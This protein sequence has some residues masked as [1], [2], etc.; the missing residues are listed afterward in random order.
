MNDKLERKLILLFASCG[1]L[2]TLTLVSAI[3]V[4]IYLKLK[5]QGT[6]NVNVLEVK[7]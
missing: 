2:V 3:G 7:P 4:D 1:V 5:N 6:R